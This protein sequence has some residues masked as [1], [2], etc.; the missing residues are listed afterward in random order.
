M[1]E[2]K[3]ACPAQP[4]RG[5]RVHQDTNSACSTTEGP[6]QGGHLWAGRA[7]PQPGQAKG[8]LHTRGA[9]GMSALSDTAMG[10]SKKMQAQSKDLRCHKVS[11]SFLKLERMVAA[12]LPFFHFCCM[13]FINHQLINPVELCI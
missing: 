12:T 9:R 1:Q 4:L 7:R 13:S 5:A 10:K 11:F 2:A 3:Q 6:Q 8:L